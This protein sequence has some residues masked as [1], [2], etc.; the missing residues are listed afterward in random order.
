MTNDSSSCTSDLDDSQPVAKKSKKSNNKN[1]TQSTSTSTTPKNSTILKTSCGTYAGSVSPSSPAIGLQ[2]RSSNVTNG[3][4]YLRI[5]VTTSLKKAPA[6]SDAY[7]SNTN[8]N[9]KGTFTNINIDDLS[10]SLSDLTSSV[11]EIVQNKG[12][13]LAEY[14]NDNV[15]GVSLFLCGRAPKSLEVVKEIGKKH[16]T[17]MLCK[18]ELAKGIVSIFSL[19]VLLSLY[20]NL[21]CYFK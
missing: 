5:M 4:L 7:F 12:F 13:E 18:G 10:V 15:Q 1:A 2:P 14:Q 20:V 17:S 21:I 19:I 16:T 8:E 6:F 9:I 3:S 11:L